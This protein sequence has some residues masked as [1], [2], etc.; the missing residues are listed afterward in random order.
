[1]NSITKTKFQCPLT[2]ACA[3]VN[4]P[5]SARTT[6]PHQQNSVSPNAIRTEYNE[7]EV[8]A[9]TY[10]SEFRYKIKYQNEPHNH[11]KKS[12]TS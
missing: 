5:D 7:Q 2:L 4:L 9:A 8:T 12:M 6:S 10:N 11:N 3:T 1:M